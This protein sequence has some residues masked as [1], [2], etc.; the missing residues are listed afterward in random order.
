M[1]HKSKPSS[2]RLC[3]TRAPQDLW[4][5][6]Q[7][8][9]S[10]L[11]PFTRAL[12]EESSRRGA[13]PWGGAE[14]VEP[15]GALRALTA[16]PFQNTNTHLPFLP[17]LAQMCRFS[18]WGNVPSSRFASMAA[19]KAAMFTQTP[20]PRAIGFCAFVPSPLKLFS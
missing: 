14:V 19:K 10:S 13:K 1:N 15:A 9:P 20:L 7:S 5:W 4:H 3:H 6:G 18:S 17:L 16:L 8:V 11:P 12:V 2:V